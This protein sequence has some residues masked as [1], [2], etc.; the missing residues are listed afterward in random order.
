MDKLRDYIYQGVTYHATIS[1]KRIRN[2]ILKLGKKPYEIKVSAPYLTSLRS[3][4]DFVIKHLPKLLS[5][6]KPVAEPF[7]QGFIYLFGVRDEFEGGEKEAHALWKQK[8]L[9]YLEERVRH[10]ESMMGIKEPYKVR[11]RKMTSRWGVNSKRT[12]SVTFSTFL[13]CFPKEVID[14]V[15]VHE[16][17]HHFRFDHSPKFYALVYTYCPEYKSLHRYLTKRIYEGPNHL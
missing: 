15:V 6:V 1:F 17:C 11:M 3:I 14:T 13:M 8:G 7:G 16:L 5:R 2:L 4:D 9:P 12:H 10:Y